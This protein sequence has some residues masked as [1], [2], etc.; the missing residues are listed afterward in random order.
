MS[1]KTTPLELGTESIGKLLRQYATP[2]IIAMTASSLYNITDSI[3]IGHGVGE[4]ALSGLGICFPLMNL[5]AA[6]GSLVGAGGATLL[7]I[8]MGQ[9]DYDTANKIL[10]NVLILNVIIGILF[11]VVTLA[12][13][14]PILRFFGA[15]EELLPYARE[16]MIPLLIGNV[17]TH[18]YM[19]LNALLRSA[20]HPEK[21]MYATIS[22]VL[23]NVVL[24]TIFIFGLKMGIMGSAI[25]TVVSQ[26]IMLIWQLKFFSNKD[27]FIHIKKSIF[28]LRKKIVFDILSIG[29]APFLMNA[30]ACLI[31]VVINQGLVKYGGNLAVGAYSIVN[32]ISFLFIMIVMGLTQGMQ[33]ISGYNFGAKQYDRVNEVL[34]KTIIIATIIMTCG[35][36]IVELF[37]RLVSSIF[38]THE[39]LTAMATT[40]LRLTFLIYPIVGFQIVTSNF[41]QSIGMA[42][43]AIFLSLSRQLIFLL[44]CLFILPRFYGLNG[45]WVSF[46]IADSAACIIAFFLLLNQFRVFK[47]KAEEEA[48]EAEN[49]EVNSLTQ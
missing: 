24:N 46:P 49:K 42:S 41:F 39:E 5:A 47:K 35:F 9:K 28:K 11:S 31:V 48:L 45:I 36:I 33:P 21:A 13:L 10:G 4:M 12:F 18:M 20:G 27:F 23:I 29:S 14:D 6:F 43:K 19:G 17:V 37:P 34:K 2:A 26:L 25:A 38:T 30:A 15:T 16:Y 22:T 8:R 32:R 1:S 44:P 7:S 40:G 3:F